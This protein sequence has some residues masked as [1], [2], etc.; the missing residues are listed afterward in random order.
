LFTLKHLG[1]V[2]FKKV[3]CWPD[4]ASTVI[5]PLS[6]TFMEVLWVFN[7]AITSSSDVNKSLRLGY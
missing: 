4:T 3:L 2:P 6:E 5:L 7:S 1:A